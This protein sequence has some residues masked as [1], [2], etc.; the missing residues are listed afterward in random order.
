MYD[1]VY[2]IYNDISWPILDTLHR[3]SFD[4]RI[5][6]HQDMLKEPIKIDPDLR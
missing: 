6:V 1:Y 4:P 3:S 2:I 5:D